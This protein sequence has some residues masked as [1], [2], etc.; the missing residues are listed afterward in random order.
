MRRWAEALLNADTA[1]ISDVAL[2]LDKTLMRRQGR[3]R[4]KA[5]ATSIADVGGRLLLD[6]VLG[7]DC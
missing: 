4:T 2:G 5:W 1:Q 6:M 3:F 7:Q